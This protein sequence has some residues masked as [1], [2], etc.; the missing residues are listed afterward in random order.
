[1]KVLVIEMDDFFSLYSERRFT[2]ASI[3]SERRRYWCGSEP[4]SS[5]TSQAS[6]LA[7]VKK[8]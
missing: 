6:Q 1:M 8:F 3:N 7:Q 5:V 4:R 2:N